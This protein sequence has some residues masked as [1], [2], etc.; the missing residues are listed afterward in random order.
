[1]SIEDLAIKHDWACFNAS[2]Y[3]Q[4]YHAVIS[5]FDL[6]D[7][8]SIFRF[9]KD[10]GET[11]GHSPNMFFD[12]EWYRMVYPD[13]LSLIESGKVSSGFEHYHQYGCKDRNPNCFFD[14]EFYCRTQVCMSPEQLEAHGLRNGYDHFLRYGAHE[15][16]DASLFFSTTLFIRENPDFLYDDRNGIFAAFLENATDHTVVERRTSAYF[17]PEWYMRAYPDMSRHIDEWQHPLR[18]YLGNPSPEA[19]DPNPFFSE[20]FYTQG[21]PDVTAVIADGCFRNAYEHFIR[22]GQYE[23]RRPHARVNLTSYAQDPAISDVVGQG[24]YPTPFAAYAMLYGKFPDSG[25]E[26]HGPEMVCKRAYRRMSEVRTALLLK[27]CMDF[28][29]DLPELSVVMVVHDQFAFT[30][31]ALASLRATCDAA[32]QLILVDGASTDE[33]ILIERHVRGI[34]VIQ[35]SENVG[36][37]AGANLGLAR[38]AAPYVLFLNNDVELLPG[39]VNAACARLRRDER[40]GAVGAK[41]VR[42]TGEL[43]EAGCIVWNDGTTSGYLRGASPM[44]P[45]ANFVRS[46]DFCSGAFLLARTEVV[47]ELN[48]FDPLFAPAYY[49]ETDLCVQIRQRGF[50]IVYDPDVVVLHYEFGSGRQDD[51]DACLGRNIGKFFHKNRD[52]VEGKYRRDESNLLKARFAESGNRRVLFIEDYLPQ[53]AIGAGFPRSNDIVRTMVD[54]LGAHVTVY[55]IFPPRSQPMTRYQDFPDRAEIIWDRG[56]GDLAAFLRTRAG[57]YDIIW[58]GRTHNADRLKPIFT[59]CET[60]LTGC[61]VVLDTEALTALRLQGRMR[62]M[63]QTDL[64]DLEGML[65]YEL[66]NTDFIDRFVTVSKGE[67]TLIRGIVNQDVSVLGHMQTPVPRSRAFSERRHFLFVG[68]I[69][70]LESPNW[71][72]LA[73]LNDHVVPL[74]D[75]FLPEDIRIRVAGY[76][77]NGIDL[78]SILTHPR[79]ELLGAVEDL[80]PLYDTHRVFI[81]PTRFAAGIPY[82]I[83]EAAAHGLPIVA[84]DLL[85]QQV[86]WEPGGDI[87]GAS[88][89]Q[90]LAFA[91]GMQ[92]VY[93]DETLWNQLRRNALHRIFLENRA[94]DYTRAV[95]DILNFKN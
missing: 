38:V 94:D 53:R 95:T 86:G 90:P 69:Q 87:A 19:F 8:G 60:A 24:K 54:M 92:Q 64:P 22:Y 7:D 79:F 55:P 42:T 32:I 34:E 33:T 36:F 68:A 9:Y 70:N 44:L 88:E 85:I 50:E 2:W 3:K 26:S 48:G 81:A 67:A 62:I 46:V 23:D 93:T 82:K 4:H 41:L 27:Q 45:E 5:A 21:N 6:H 14:E 63:G 65:R 89:T 28:S 61:R 11:L 84:T 47:K 80:V 71:D 17:D 83:H 75:N 31:T 49:E 10:F 43:Q 59:A 57:Y 25:D 15:K 37:L 29:C 12:E 20:R 58:I 16:R 56:L 40:A 39:A 66:R 74:L 76:V 72:G 35:L 1:M 13:V 91:G 30:M 18:H 73:W 51:I 77:G 52:Y 78:S